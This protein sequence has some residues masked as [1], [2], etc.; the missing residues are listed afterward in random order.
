MDVAAVEVSRVSTTIVY[1][2]SPTPDRWKRGFR[3]LVYL[4]VNM[5]GYNVKL[6][7]YIRIRVLES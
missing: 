7:D 4:T 3:S 5:K 2:V 6:S 1:E